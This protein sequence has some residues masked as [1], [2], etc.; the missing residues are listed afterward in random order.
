MPKPTFSEGKIKTIALVGPQSTGKST[1]AKQLAEKYKTA[2]VPEYARQYFTQNG[3]QFTYRTV[4]PI[5]RHQVA[6]EQRSLQLARRFLFCD[7]DALTTLIWSDIYFNKYPAWLLRHVTERP[8][9][10]YL[11]LDKDLAFEQDDQREN[12]EMQLLFWEKFHHY[13]NKFKLPYAVVS[14]RGESRLTNAA[15]ACNAFFPSYQNFTF[16]A[17]PSSP[18]SQW[19]PAGFTVEGTRYCCAEQ[20]MMHQKA[21][22]FND[23]EMAEKI[24][25]VSRPVEHQALGRAVRNFDRT[26]WKIYCKEIVYRG[27][28]A[29]FSQ[30]ADLWQLLQSTRD[31][32]LVEVYEHCNYW[33]VG[34][35]QHDERLHN[36]AQWTGQNWVGFILTQVRE[37]LAQTQ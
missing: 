36:P 9:H 32:V 21:L 35:G 10:L 5:A 13:L 20:F 19:Y 33:S 4:T 6:D 8:H 28:H 2:W 26:R 1:L 24:M 25:Q 22:L 27:N 29:K 17:D 12:Q 31:T 37:D 14:G 18:F 34:L 7:T 11:L 15:L 16:F 30:N 3:G 23:L